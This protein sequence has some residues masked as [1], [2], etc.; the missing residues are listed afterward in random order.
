MKK[1]DYLG[2][3]EFLAA[4]VS[5]HERCQH[6]SFDLSLP[7]AADASYQSVELGAVN[8]ACSI[9][10]AATSTPDAAL[11]RFT[12]LLQVK[13]LELEK[14]ASV[15]SRLD[16]SNALHRLTNIDAAQAFLVRIYRDLSELEAQ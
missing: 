13:G 8:V 11:Y 16:V 4:I 9:K 14:L 6:T 3:R 5:L 12:V 15:G 2:E 7:L 10:V 1:P